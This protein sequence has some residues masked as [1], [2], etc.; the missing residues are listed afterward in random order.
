MR[1]SASLLWEFWCLAGWVVLYPALA[2]AAPAATARPGQVAFI[3]DPGT[4]LP[5][6]SAAMRNPACHFK[7]FVIP[8]LADGV[9]HV[10]LESDVFPRAQRSVGKAALGGFI[11]DAH[12]K[13]VLVYGYVDCLRWASVQTAGDPAS[14]ANRF[15]ALVE[16]DDNGDSRV[17]GDGVYASP[18]SSGVSSALCR[19][20]RSIR[21]GFPEMDGVVLRCELPASVV[22][23]YAEPT[24]AAYI[25]AEG[26]DPLD[27][28][29]ASDMADAREWAAWRLSQVA[30]L[31]ARVASDFRG[32]G[33]SRRVLAVGSAAWPHQRVG[34]RNATLGDWP[35][36]V[37]SGAVDGVLL[38]VDPGDA[39]SVRTFVGAVRQARAR[40]GATLMALLPDTVTKDGPAGAASAVADLPGGAD[41]YVV[42]VG[43]DYLVAATGGR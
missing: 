26:R 23:G 38:D 13:G 32:L 35:A 40:R 43:H 12:S 22:L 24:R 2:N 19:L 30:G 1:R 33:T 16:R 42:R 29:L 8:C 11:R 9:L 41:G 6:A 31:V 3:A 15:P 36:W 4:D 5:L 27:I 10:A 28:S 14:P 18:F 21:A 39:D 7:A 37:G 20:A 25:A 34:E 17:L